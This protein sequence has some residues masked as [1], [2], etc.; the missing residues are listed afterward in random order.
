MKDF[1]TPVH[2][3]IHV[4]QTIEQALVEIRSHA[5]REKI[6]YFY[7]INDDNQLFGVV[8]TRKLLL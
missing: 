1:V 5:I 2:T 6:I 4:N 3:V 8:S 7:V